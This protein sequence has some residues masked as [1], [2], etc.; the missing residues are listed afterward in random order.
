MNNNTL[1]KYINEYSELNK[2]YKAIEKKLQ[3]LKANILEGM[4]DKN[5]YTTS[6]NITAKIYEKT[7]V[8]ADNKMLEKLYPLIWQEVKKVTEYKELRI[9]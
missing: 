1:S 7:R 3:E 6:D 5:E 9:R 4:N 2:E 8:Y